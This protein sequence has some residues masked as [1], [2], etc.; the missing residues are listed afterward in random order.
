MT[1]FVKE[2]RLKVH[3]LPRFLSFPTRR[4]RGISG[5][6]RKMYSPPQ[7]ERKRAN[8]IPKWGVASGEGRQPLSKNFPPSFGKG[9]GLG[10]WISQGD[11]GGDVDKKIPLFKSG[12]KGGNIYGLSHG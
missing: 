2:C 1:L 9:R 11:T 5:L 4:P 3:P 8:L 10:G 7:Y 12:G 6:S